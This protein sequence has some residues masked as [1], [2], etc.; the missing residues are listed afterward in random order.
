MNKTRQK[1]GKKCCS[2]CGKNENE[3]AHIIH[4]SKVG[5]CK[6]CAGFF[7]NAFNGGG[8]LLFEN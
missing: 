3:V 5:I 1:H 8:A 4:V 6:E 2:F 7:H